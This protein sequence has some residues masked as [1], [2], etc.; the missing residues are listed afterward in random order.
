M[1]VLSHLE[2]KQNSIKTT[3]GIMPSLISM[4]ENFSI[5]WK[6]NNAD[7]PLP[8][9]K[10]KIMKLGK[11]FKIWQTSHQNIHQKVMPIKN[12]CTNKILKL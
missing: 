2:G 10:G 8:V 5:E 11:R 7:E 6:E 3:E 1:N 9:I 12:H 4:N